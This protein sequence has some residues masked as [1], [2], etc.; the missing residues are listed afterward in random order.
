MGEDTD[1]K[2]AYAFALYPWMVDVEVHANFMSTVIAL[3]KLYD[4]SS[5]AVS[6]ACL[7]REARAQDALSDALL[8]STRSD[9]KRAGEIWKKL[10]VIRNKN[11]AHRTAV[12]QFESVFRQA[13]IKYMEV[14]ELVDLSRKVLNSFCGAR[15][16]GQWYPDYAVRKDIEKLWE[17]ILTARFQDI[18]ERRRFDEEIKA[19][20]NDQA[21]PKTV[22]RADS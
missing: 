2:F 3:G 17:C 10:R 8:A 7:V 12:E 20:T 6:I 4:A 16:T 22:G 5:D 9:R 13:D 21:A 14:E 15:G 18:A 19:V 11:A 1:S